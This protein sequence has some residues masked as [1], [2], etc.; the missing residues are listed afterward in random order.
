MIRWREYSKALRSPCLTGTLSP[1]HDCPPGFPVEIVGVGE[2]HAAFLNESRTRCR[3]Q[4][5]VGRDRCRDKVAHAG[6]ADRITSPQWAGLN[7]RLCSGGFLVSQSGRA[8][9]THRATSKIAPKIQRRPLC[10]C[11]G[12]ECRW[13]DLT[14]LRYRRRKPIYPRRKDVLLTIT[15]GRVSL[16][17]PATP[18]I[19]RLGLPRWFERLLLFLTFLVSLF[20]RD[21]GTGG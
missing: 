5:S 14:E 8:K 7:T 6:M 16:C 4:R 10:R 13:S 1:A 9:A 19:A 2:V 21:S 20:S 12:G 17:A 15:I 3:V 18:C 11:P